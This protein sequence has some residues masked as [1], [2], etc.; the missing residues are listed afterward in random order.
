MFHANMRR[1]YLEDIPR[2]PS[3]VRVF[4]VCFICRFLLSVPMGVDNIRFGWDTGESMHH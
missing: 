4:E 1:K 3:P 2:L